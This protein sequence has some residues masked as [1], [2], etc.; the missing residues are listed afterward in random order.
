MNIA[1]PKLDPLLEKF[2]HK[3][4][5][6]HPSAV[7]LVHKD[8]T[9]LAANPL[10]DEM[11]L[12]RGKRCVK[13]GGISCQRCQANQAL[14]EN[15]GKHAVSYYP[16]LEM[17]L[18]SYWVPIKGEKNLFLHYAVDITNYAAERMFPQKSD[19]E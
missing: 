4:W 10:A 1:K 2:F 17:V 8:R 18:D 14:K 3:M 9:I 12:S 19:T 16:E 13:E 6:N 7:M 11:G 5:D 15:T